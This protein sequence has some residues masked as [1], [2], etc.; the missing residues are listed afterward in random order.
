M[1]SISFRK[2]VLGVERFGVNSSGLQE[3]IGQVQ[4]LKIE[5][6]RFA[7]EHT[8]LEYKNR[9]K[10][11]DKNKTA[12]SRRKWNVVGSVSIGGPAG[13]ILRVTTT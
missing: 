4:A 6:E 9:C 3:I 10:K 11:M 7:K 5:Y 8:D 12:K 1:H 2:A 13:Q